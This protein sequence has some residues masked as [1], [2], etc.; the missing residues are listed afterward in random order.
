MIRLFWVQN[1]QVYT[2]HSKKVCDYT[3]HIIILKKCF[4]V[5]KSFLTILFYSY[6]TVYIMYVR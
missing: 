1:G 5:K 3:R 2:Q 6:Y 4:P